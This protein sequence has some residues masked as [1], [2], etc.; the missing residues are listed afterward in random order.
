[1]PLKNYGILKGK[2]IEVRPGAGQNPHYQVYIVDDT[3]DYRIAINVQSKLSPSELEFLVDDRFSHPITALLE[4]VPLGFTRTPKP[5]SSLSQA[6]TSRS[7]MGLK[8]ST[9]RF[10]SFG[11]VAPSRA[12]A[13]SPLSGVAGEASGKQ[14]GGNVRNGQP[15]MGCVS[16]RGFPRAGATAPDRSCSNG[17]SMLGPRS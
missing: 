15:S 2:A 9:N 16:P 3:T 1:M 5:R 13:A 4:E 10:E 8:A 6:N 12:A 7:G 17:W 11:T 14:L